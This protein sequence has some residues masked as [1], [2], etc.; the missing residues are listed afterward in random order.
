VCICYI[1][2]GGENGR[3]GAS[4]ARVGELEKK[5]NQT[6]VKREGKRGE[7]ILRRSCVGKGQGMDERGEGRPNFLVG[8][9]RRSDSVERRGAKG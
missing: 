4:S 8:G 6:Q 5:S 9:T 3:K 7:N 2:T 1:T